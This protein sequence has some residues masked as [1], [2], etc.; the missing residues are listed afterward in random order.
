MASANTDGDGLAKFY[1][2]GELSQNFTLKL[3]TA[4][5]GDDF[6]FIN[7]SD[8][9][10]ETSRFDVSGKND[11]NGMFDS[12][13]YGDRNLYRPGEKIYVT[14]IVRNL[15]NALPENMPVRSQDI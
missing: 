1:N 4:E 13:L 5:R 10:I 2:F 11:M 7:L 9:R 8:Y 12:F 14:G 3:V 15:T 6:N